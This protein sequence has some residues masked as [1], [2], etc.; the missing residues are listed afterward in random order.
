MKEKIYCENWN[1]FKKSLHWLKISYEKCKNFNFEDKKILEEENIESLE[2]LANRFCRSVDILIN[3]VLRSLDILELE[4]ISRKLDIVIRAEKRGFVE[5]YNK[6]IEL[7]NI[8]NELAHEYIIDNLLDKFKI[9]IIETPV[10]FE[11]E[12]K[13]DEYNKI[14]SYCENEKR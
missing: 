12:N 2:T 1:M 11:I 13:I 10:L 4:N 7:K 8:R 9:I 6:L 14:Y 3:K 5:D